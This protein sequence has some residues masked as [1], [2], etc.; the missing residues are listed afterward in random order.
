MDGI[1]SSPMH[2][3][4]MEFL[5]P[6]SHCKLGAFCQDSS[7]RGAAVW[8]SAVGGLSAVT[9][10]WKWSCDLPTRATGCV[11]GCAPFWHARSH[12]RTQRTLHSKQRITTRPR[13]ARTC[14]SAMAGEGRAAFSAPSRS[15][16]RVPASTP[17]ENTGTHRH[18]MHVGSLFSF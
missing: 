8:L 14:C 9:A 3:Y 6:S 13:T 16:S 18:E 1:K 10:S 12:A 17:L 2:S 11:S 15:V 4:D 7:S 5:F